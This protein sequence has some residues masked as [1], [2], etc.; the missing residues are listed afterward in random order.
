MKRPFTP[1]PYPRLLTSP[2][3]G[4]P[5][6][7][8]FTGKPHAELLAG[9]VHGFHHRDGVCPGVQRRFGVPGMV[10]AGHL[11]S[12]VLE[13]TADGGAHLDRVS[14]GA[15]HGQSGGGVEG[16]VDLDTS[17]GAAGDRSGE[18]R[19]GRGWRVRVE[20]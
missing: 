1:A 10:T 20:G 4:P 3:A 12:L 6:A 11:R 7:N 13:S 16:S 14:V 17:L 5:I 19:V 8:S 15:A 18:R 2:A 9:G